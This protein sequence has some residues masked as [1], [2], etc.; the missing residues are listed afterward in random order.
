MQWTYTLYTPKYTED[1]LEKSAFT[2]IQSAANATQHAVNEA[3]D[4][5]IYVAELAI[6][7]NA[8]S[9]TNLRNQLNNLRTTDVAEPTPLSSIGSPAFDSQHSINIAFDN[10]LGETK[11]WTTQDNQGT[12]EISYV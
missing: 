6:G 10:L 8:T 4:H 12:W 5:E 9:I 2:H 3:I 1:I 11:T 7:N